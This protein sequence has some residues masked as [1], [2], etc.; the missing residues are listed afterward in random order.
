MPPAVVTPSCPHINQQVVT[1]P[2]T[3][4]VRATHNH[5]LW[6]QH[7]PGRCPRSSSPAAR[8]RCPRSNAILRLRYRQLQREWALFGM[9]HLCTFE[10]PFPSPRDDNLQAS[11]QAERSLFEIEAALSWYG[12][13]CIRRMVALTLQ[14]LPPLDPS[15]QSVKTELGNLSLQ[16]CALL[17]TQTPSCSAFTS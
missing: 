5:K 8:S 2:S 12:T 17:C 10:V 4:A 13:V 9:C 7:A 14:L 3:P 15:T 11:A 6:Q 16:E 1:N